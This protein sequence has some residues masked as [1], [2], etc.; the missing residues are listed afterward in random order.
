MS[1]QEG[2]SR[3]LSPEDFEIKTISEILEDFRSN[4]PAQEKIFG[5]ELTKKE[6]DKR[7][8]SGVKAEDLVKIQEAMGLELPTVDVVD[9]LREMV[10]KGEIKVSDI[11][12]HPEAEEEK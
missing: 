11:Y 2:E 6:F 5:K 9:R 10:K 4:K 3:E 7:F 8:S 12:I 1:K